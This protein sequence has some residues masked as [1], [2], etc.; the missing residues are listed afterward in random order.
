MGLQQLD[1]QPTLAHYQTVPRQK[2]RLLT[3]FQAAILRHLLTK[4][5]GA[6]KLLSEAFLS[7]HQEDSFTCEPP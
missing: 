5:Q 4:F 1:E 6:H 2:A 7:F 3:K